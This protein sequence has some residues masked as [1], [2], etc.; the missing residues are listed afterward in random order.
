MPNKPKTVESINEAWDKESGCYDIAGSVR[1]LIP[2]F[3][4]SQYQRLIEEAVDEY[5]NPES[6]KP[7]KEMLKD[8]GLLK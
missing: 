7:L 6:N 1:P 5:F 4:Q 3:F 2:H 8:R